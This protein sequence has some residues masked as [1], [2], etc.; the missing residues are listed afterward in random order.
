[1]CNIKKFVII[2]ILLDLLCEQATSGDK[3]VFSL[4]CEWNFSIHEEK[5]QRET[6]QCDCRQELPGLPTPCSNGGWDGMCTDR[7]FP[8]TARYNVCFFV[9]QSVQAGISLSLVNCEAVLHVCIV[10]GPGFM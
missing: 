1:M 2:I 3:L 7:Q 5:G 6:T 4:F 9:C 8:G 10:Y